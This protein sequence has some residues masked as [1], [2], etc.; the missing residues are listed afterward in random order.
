MAKMEKIFKPLNETK[1]NLHWDICHEIDHTMW[2]F[3]IFS[4]T[5]ILCETNV[6][7]GTLKTQAIT[8]I[9]FKNI[10][11]RQKNFHPV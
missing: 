4:A 1:L 10:S 9:D 6:V 3:K 5:Q 11:G 2:N 8:F 7:F